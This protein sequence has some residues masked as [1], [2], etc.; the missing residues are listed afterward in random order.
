MYACEGTAGWKLQGDGGGGGSGDITDVWGCATGNCDALTAAAGDSFD[1]GSADSTDPFQEAATAGP[2][3]EGRAIWDSDDDILE[4]GDGA[5]AVPLNVIP[6]LLSDSAGRTGTF[7]LAPY[8]CVGTSETVCRNSYVSMDVRLSD[9]TCR[10]TNAPVSPATWTCN[11]KVNNVSQANC[12]IATTN[13]SCDITGSVAVTAD[14]EFH[15][16]FVE[17]GTA[18]GTGGGSVVCDM[19]ILGY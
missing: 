5:E 12:V 3:V 15:F 6:L 8:G 7:Y 10:V 11:L 17:T 4:V 16:S 2:T 14:Q 13:T 19:A 9:C 1:A 18:A